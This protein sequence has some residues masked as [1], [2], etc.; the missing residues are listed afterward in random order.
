MIQ[1]SARQT[2]FCCVVSTITPKTSST[3]VLVN[4]H[5]ELHNCRIFLLKFKYRGNQINED[6]VLIHAGLEFKHLRGNFVVLH[7]MPPKG[8]R[9]SQRA[10]NVS[11]LPPLLDNLLI[12]LIPELSTTFDN[13]ISKLIRCLL[14]ENQEELS[15]KLRRRYYHLVS[16]ERHDEKRYHEIL[17]RGQQELSNDPFLQKELQRIRLQASTSTQFRSPSKNNIP[18]SDFHSTLDWKGEGDSLQESDEE[19]T[20]Y[21]FIK[22]EEEQQPERSKNPIAS[23]PPIVKMPSKEATSK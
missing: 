1:Q 4:T 6:S 3:A 23:H 14:P 20:D 10:R 18:S 7:T 11:A 5:T 22:K 13:N 16:I 19:V 2:T 15:S 9:L 17:E 21:I 12:I 8:R